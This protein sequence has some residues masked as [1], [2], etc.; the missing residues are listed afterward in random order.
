L[1]HDADETTPRQDYRYLAGLPTDP[2]AFPDRISHERPSSDRSNCVFIMID[3]LLPR[4][5]VPPKLQA[6]F[7]LGAGRAPA[8]PDQEVRDGSGGTARS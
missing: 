2:N 5:A 8:D 4:V 7:L 1:D 3:K 6:T